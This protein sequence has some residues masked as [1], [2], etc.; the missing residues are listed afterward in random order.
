MWIDNGDGTYTAE[1]GDTLWG[2]YGKDWRE[3]SGYEGDP[4]KLQI[5]EVVGKLKT[6]TIKATGSGIGFFVSAI[7]G[8]AGSQIDKSWY[9]MM[10]TIVETGEKFFAKFTTTSVEGE[11][12]KLGL[13]LYTITLEASAIYKGKPPT[14]EQIISDFTGESKSMGF[15]IMFVGVSGSEANQWTVGTGNLN[16]SVGFPFTFTAEK[17]ITKEIK[18]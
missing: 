17:S 9:E 8:E 16:I 7:V 15:G 18:K 2:L 12:F 4:T 1:K 6:T 11:G 13:G 14:R 10:F 5:G 3:K